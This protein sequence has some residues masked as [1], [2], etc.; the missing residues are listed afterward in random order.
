MVFGALSGASTHPW[1]VHFGGA[2]RGKAPRCKAEGTPLPE[3]PSLVNQRIRGL[4]GTVSRLSLWPDYAPRRAHD[5]PAVRQGGLQSLDGVGYLGRELAALG[6][7][8]D[9]HQVSIGDR[10]VHPIARGVPISRSCNITHHP[11]HPTWIPT[12]LGSRYGRGRRQTRNN[13]AQRRDRPRLGTFIPPGGNPH[14]TR[15]GRHA[16]VGLVAPLGGAFGGAF[17]ADK[18]PRCKAEGTPL[19]EVPSLFNQ[20]ICGLEDRIPV[21]AYVPTMR[22]GGPTIRWPSGKAASS[23]SSNTS[24]KPRP[25]SFRNR[26]ASSPAASGAPPNTAECIFTPVGIWGRGPPSAW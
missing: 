1:G 17:R 26:A 24:A 7:L 5:P 14:L 16:T 21:L 22:Q 23:R 13:P 10:I 9:F 3:V 19:P 18:A 12:R 25:G 6:T 11:K 20:R 2:F 15:R 8:G 4:T